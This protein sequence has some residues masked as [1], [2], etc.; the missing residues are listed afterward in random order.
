MVI[1]PDS[2]QP[3]TAKK[4]IVKVDLDAICLW[5]V[6]WKHYSQTKLDTEIINAA[7]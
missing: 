1:K 2:V 6:G 4:S 3:Y 5:E 7:E